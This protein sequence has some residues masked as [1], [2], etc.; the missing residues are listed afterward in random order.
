M[1]RSLCL[2]VI[3]VFLSGAALSA[4]PPKT[5]LSAQYDRWIKQEVV[6]IIT[7]DEKKS[8]LKLATDTERDR[9]I[10]DFWAVRNPAR[11][12]PVN[13]YKEEHYRR[14]QYATDTFGR[15]S[16]TPGWMT[17]MGRAWILFGKPVS[18]APYLGYGQLYPCELWFYENK[19]S[20][21][22]L[23]GFFTLL[24]FMPE[25]VGEY[26]FYRP[27]LDTPLK[28][29]R[30]S[31]FNSNRDVYNF[32]KPIAGDLAKAAFTLIP[33]DPVDTTN[34]TV[35]MSSDMLVGRIQNFANDPFNVRKLREMRSLHTSV[36]SKLLITDE[37][38]LQIDALILADPIGQSWLDYSVL[39]RDA[40]MG[41]VQTG[42]PQHLSVASG[43][44]LLTSGGE[45]IVEDEEERSFS[46]F[47]TDGLFQPFQLAGRLPVMP[48]S[49]TLE[50]RIIDRQR[51]RIFH[52]EKKFTVGVPGAVTLTG[53]LL[54]SAAKQ[55]PQPDAAAPFQYFGVQ[56]QPLSAGDQVRTQPLRL[57]YSLDVPKDQPE[58]TVEYLVAHLQDR[59]ARL[60]VK[61][62]IPSGE[63]RE[64]HLLKSKTI[65]LG[66]LPAGSYRVVVTIHGA[67]VNGA[68]S[69]AVL[70]SSS[71]SVRLVDSS[72]P[73][74]LFF[75]DSARKSA[76]PAGASYIRAL[77]AISSKDQPAA[78]RYMK[79]ALDLNP[80]N[81]S[82]ARY[83]VQTYFE[84]HEFS[85]I[86]G[87][88]RKLGIKPFEASAE[89]LAQ[90][91]LSFARTGDR[92]QAQEILN[93]ARAL[94]PENSL[95][96]A[97]AKA[98]SN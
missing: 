81:E 88:Y 64:G 30:G 15:R 70:A 56:F 95:L 66:D 78:T 57:L 14:L 4:P 82:A 62:N 12:S 39:V 86:T 8:F 55:T 59:E 41:Q 25:D 42:P 87:L 6:Y 60:S 18:R 36:E 79:Q 7:D 11:R 44:R 10:E 71:L 84:T 72:A 37:T 52:G 9:F 17:D 61:E 89:S 26:R 38:P 35:D 46:A 24:F 48:G 75:L 90:I 5:T 73:L 51:S 58:Y 85:T 2:F 47:G 69:Q 93:T 21:P 49:Y 28:L 20:G 74:P 96:V 63:F 97:T 91:S 50:F 29:V 33:G 16:N 53:P 68:T 43:F 31:Q 76:V 92:R 45:L 40:G 27:S 54:F 22:S 3:G 32:L 83:L 67:T 23:P 80:A 98:V 13:S 77:E 94:F 34:Y 65:P 19:I 1:V